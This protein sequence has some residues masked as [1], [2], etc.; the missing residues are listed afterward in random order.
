[1]THILYIWRL[2]NGKRNGNSRFKMT[3]RS[4]QMTSGVHRAE[5]E[6][7]SSVV[8]VASRNSHDV[9][10]RQQS[11]CTRVSRTADLPP[12][13]TQRSSSLNV[14]LPPAR[15]RLN[16]LV[17]RQTVSLTVSAA[18]RMLWQHATT[19]C[20]RYRQFSCHF[21]AVRRRQ[22]VNFNVVFVTN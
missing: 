3:A 5:V 1:L 21:S 9:I 19:T 2:Y 15:A 20:C 16:L 17:L 10:P 18:R 12:S 11:Q 7:V 14:S 22:R 8:G 4:E 13:C 6:C